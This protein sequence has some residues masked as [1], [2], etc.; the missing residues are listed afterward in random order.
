MLSVLG[1]SHV[2]IFGGLYQPYFPEFPAW[3]EAPGR[4]VA[5]LGPALA[6]HLADY[7]NWAHVAFCAA[8]QQVPKGET[9]LMVFGEIDCRAHIS[10]HPERVH[11]TALAYMRAVRE[12]RSAGWRPAVWGVI[13]SAR[14]GVHT[15]R[16][17]PCFGTCRERNALTRRFNTDV[18]NLC[19][20]S[21]IPFAS[22]FDA[23]VGADGLTDERYFGPDRMH[24]GEGAW[25]TV[26]GAMKGLQW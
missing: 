2:G 4:R 3:I 14:D 7:G 13:P 26:E 18:G 16:D 1:D 9:V 8:L 17:F 19:A 11:G 15:Q 24:L 10:K 20:E 21:A 22:V 6:Y 5:H 12:V 25:A 23:M